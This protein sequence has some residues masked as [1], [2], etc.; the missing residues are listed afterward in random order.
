MSRIRSAR[1]KIPHR[2]SGRL[3][4]GGDGG[5]VKGQQVG[6]SLADAGQQSLAGEADEQSL[7]LVGLQGG[8]D[9]VDGGDEE[10]ASGRGEQCLGDLGHGRVDDRV[11][12]RLD[13]LDA[14][15]RGGLGEDL[16]DKG[17]LGEGGPGDLVELGQLSSGHVGQSLGP[18]DAEQ[19]GTKTGDLYVWLG[20]S[21]TRT[22]VSRSCR[23]VANTHVRG[24]HR[25]PR[26]GVAG[27]VPVGPDGQDVQTGRKDVDTLAQ[28]AT[29]V[30]RQEISRTDRSFRRSRRLGTHLK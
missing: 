17:R 21:A 12:A 9:L 3:L 7:E 8:D 29:F 20:K 4:L 1:S 23:L 10:L 16:L 2:S 26:D 5:V 15:G 13:D 30:H 28:V 27:H 6:A 18:V 14:G 24:S 22:H 19:V 25:S 11:D